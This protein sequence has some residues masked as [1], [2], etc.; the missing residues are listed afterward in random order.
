MA[1][2][3]GPGA[4]TP[5]TLTTS[6]S[7]TM[8]VWQQQQPQTMAL[9]INGC[10]KLADPAP[11]IHGGP[12]LACTPKCFDEWRTKSFNGTSLEREYLLSA[13]IR[14]ATPTCTCTRCGT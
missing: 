6:S 5:I 13:P 2:P 10:G 1:R 12:R 4:A 14:S 11:C 9:C 8:A 7:S 3:A